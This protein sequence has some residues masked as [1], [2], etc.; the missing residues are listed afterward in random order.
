MKAKTLWEWNR[1][2]Y[3]NSKAREKVT[4]LIRIEDLP[5]RLRKRFLRKPRE[6]KLKPKKEKY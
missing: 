4:Q 2:S 5:K 3:Y 6:I 1:L